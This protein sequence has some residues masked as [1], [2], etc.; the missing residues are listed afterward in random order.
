MLVRVLLRCGAPAIVR[1]ATRSVVL[2]FRSYATPGRPK[3]VVGEPSRPVK[4]AVKKA[5]AKPADG[6]SPAEKKVAAK[7]T[8]AAKKSKKAAPKK[9]TLTEEQVARLND[10]QVK[11]KARQQARSEKDKLAE[12][13]QAA[14]NPPK[15][16]HDNPYTYFMTEKFKQMGPFE[17][18]ATNQAL[19]RAFT[20][21]VAA[22][23][24]EWK[25]LNAADREVCTSA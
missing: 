20:S 12:L 10:R 11:A 25:S 7:R 21:R 8:A 18:V 24:A 9:K 22:V 2:P 19:T 15:V 1:P 6:S 5:A 13:K 23:G 14:L 17:D 3:S 16:V 4:R